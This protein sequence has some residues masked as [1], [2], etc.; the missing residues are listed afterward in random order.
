MGL[1]FADSE[2]KVLRYGMSY[3]VGGVLEGEGR[4]RGGRSLPIFR[5]CYAM[6]GTLVGCPMLLLCDVRTEE[7]Y[8]VLRNGMVVPGAVPCDRRRWVAR[9][10]R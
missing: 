2:R 4:G 10:L 6:C 1:R 5:P 8:T 9:D 3:Q 7:G